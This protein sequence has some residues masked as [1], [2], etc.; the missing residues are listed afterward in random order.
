MST[1]DEILIE[2]GISPFWKRNVKS[3]KILETEDPFTNIEST[4]A[5]SSELEAGMLFKSS[6]HNVLGDGDLKAKWLFMAEGPITKGNPLN[7]AFASDQGK[8]FDNMLAAM[9]LKRDK[10]VYLLD[11]LHVDSVGE[12]GLLLKDAVACEEFLKQRIELIQPSVIV[13]MGS[14]VVK[15]LIGDDNLSDYRLKAY[16]YHGITAVMT[17]HPLDLLEHS[18]NKVL[19]WQ[20][21]CFAIDLMQSRKNVE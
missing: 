16:D 10:D 12:E 13:A 1:R 18:S 20:D 4:S 7:R 8:L 3:S 5:C 15:R 19:A 2:L 6:A 11:V 17:F 14:V 21:L 9:H